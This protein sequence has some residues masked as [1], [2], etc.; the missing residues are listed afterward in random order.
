MSQRKFVA[1]YRVSTEKQ[2]RSG[3]GLEAQQE[4]VRTY[5]RGGDWHLMDEVVE[6]ESGKRND[7]PRLAEA[8]RLCR[9]HGAILII[10][11]LDRL[12][13]NVAFISGLME[14]G[15]EFTA[16]D[17]PQANRLTVHILAAVAEHE[18]EMI[19]RRTKDALAAAKARGKKLGGNRGKIH[20]V[21]KK[22][23]AASA[24]VRSTK[25]K[26]RAADIGPIVADIRASGATS[27]QQIAAA[28]NGRHI[29]TSRGK[30]WTPTQ[31]M[32]VLEKT[33]PGRTS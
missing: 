15:V 26:R 8:L 22:G 25:A 9:L 31:V 24:L 10:A 11:K 3:L 33:E 32:R 28:L 21:A 14:S 7:R 13:R 2:G 23:A 1:Y 30:D 18:R 27:L 29:K 6:V 20:L 5:M 16:V 19:S 17:F 4:A 12:A